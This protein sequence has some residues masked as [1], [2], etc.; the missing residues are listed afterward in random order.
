MKII[1]LLNKIAN[2]EEVPKKIKY[3]DSDNVVYE[4]EYDDN[5]DYWS[6]ILG[7]HLFVSYEIAQILNDEVEILKD[8]KKIEKI[9]YNFGLKFINCNINK[10]ARDG[11]DDEINFLHTK[12]NELIDYIYKK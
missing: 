12:I 3:K 11:I 2:G 8:N 7:G 6:K 10:E 4:F 1:D 5:N 9:N